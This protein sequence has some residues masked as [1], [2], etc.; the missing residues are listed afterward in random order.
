M[1][2]K[3]GTL[4][5]HS[6][7]LKRSGGDLWP[8]GSFNHS[9]WLLVVDLSCKASLVKPC[10]PSLGRKRQNFDSVRG[11]LIKT[12]ALDGKRFPNVLKCT[13]RVSIKY[14]RRPT[15]LRTVQIWWV[16][17]CISPCAL[18]EQAAAVFSALRCTRVV[19]THQLLRCWNIV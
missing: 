15:D 19:V 12:R 3:E 18:L 6:T 4:K 13:T 2:R 9:S 5:E 17:T 10:L 1:F 7:M 14:H 16:N 8:H 11:P